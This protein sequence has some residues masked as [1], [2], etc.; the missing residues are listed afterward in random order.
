[1]R[2]ANRI[3]N[4]TKTK[5][6]KIGTSVV[7][8][9]ATTYGA[10]ERFNGKILKKVEELSSKGRGRGQQ[11]GWQRKREGELEGLEGV[12]K[13]EGTR[14]GDEIA[15]WKRVSGGG[16]RD[17]RG[18]KMSAA[19]L[20]GDSGGDELLG[21]FKF[22]E[23]LRNCIQCEEDAVYVREC[24]VRA[25][26]RHF[27]FRRKVGLIKCSP[28]DVGY[29]HETYCAWV[30]SSRKRRIRDGHSRG[31]IWERIQLH[32]DGPRGHLVQS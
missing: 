21:S 10:D 6:R 13:S 31:D 7:S 19:C 18:R 28:S 2:R 27:C 29:R 17:N 20:N 12:M 30:L 1:M 3:F 8:S 9:R 24:T 32:E 22:R 16:S 25:L 11:K 26:V 14:N 5:E 4:V 23:L 15:E